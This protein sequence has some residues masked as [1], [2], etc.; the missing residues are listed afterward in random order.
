MSITRLGVTGVVAV[1]FLFA[2][3]AAA[4][5]DSGATPSVSEGLVLVAPSDLGARIGRRAFD[6]RPG[7]RLSAGTWHHVDLGLETGRGAAW[8]TVTAVAADQAGF[9]SIAP[10]AVGVPSTSSLS[11]D[12][13]EPV[14]NTLIVPLDGAGINVWASTAT[15]LVVD[16]REEF[17]SPAGGAGRFHAGPVVR[18]G[19]TRGSRP[20]G[21][22]PALVSVR[23]LISATQAPLWSSTALVLN[24]TGLGASQAGYVDIGGQVQTCSYD[25]QS[26]GYECGDVG[27]IVIDPYPVLHEPVA[28]STATAVTPPLANVYATSTAGDVEVV[29]DFVGWFGDGHETPA[30]ALLYPLE[31]ARICDTRLSNPGAC[32]PGRLTAG[33]SKRIDLSNYIDPSATAVVLNVT[34]TNSTRVAYVESGPAFMHT[35]PDRNVSQGTVLPIDDTTVDLTLQTGESDV[36]VDLLGYFAP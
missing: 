36:V 22:E 16:V 6:S 15:H 8:L 28:P 12:G 2:G 7:S 1:M 5:P 19:D 10:T 24:V 4:T 26:G 34:T 21:T 20:A 32:G 30:G 31:P 27:H 23:N 25:D 18:V 35:Q 13:P 29:T 11:F 3:G 33:T 17:T 9:I 14:A